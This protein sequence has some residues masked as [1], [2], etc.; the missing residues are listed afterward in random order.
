MPGIREYIEQKGGVSF[1]ELPF[2]DADN[3]TLCQIFYMPFE[4]VVSDS[5]SDAPVPFPKAVN[6]L[7]SKRSYKHRKLG[8]MIPDDASVNMMKMA[9]QPRFSEMKLVAVKEVFETN[10]AVQFAAGTFL[11]PDGTAVVIFRGTDDSIIGWKEDLDIFARKG[12]PSYALAVEYLKNAAEAFSGDLI[13]CGH[14]KGGNVGLYAVL[15]SEPAV[16]D[17]VRGIYCNDAPGYHDYSVLQTEVYDELLPRY[18]HLVPH[19]SFVGMMLAHDYDY[20]TVKSSKH[21]GPMQH[22][23]SSWQ[24]VD[25]SVV[26][27]EDVDLLAKLTDVTLSD[28]VNRVNDT[29]SAV[30]DYVANVLIDA[31]GETYLTGLVQHAATAVSGAVGAWKELAPETKETF[32]SAFKGAGKILVRNVKHIKEKTIPDAAN[33][34]AMLVRRVTVK[35]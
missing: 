31:T 6:A 30:V 5:F 27:K 21:L 13:V 4:Q 12:I 14:S 7:F 34:A 20:T 15:N 8:L 3:L 19:S 35:D 11:L 24:I 17:R 9:V 32:K 23:L 25:G 16:R 1:S 33:A 22:D 29:Q 28:I 26:T 2:G 10:P 18:R